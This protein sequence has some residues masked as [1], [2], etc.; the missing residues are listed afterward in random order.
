MDWDKLRIFH[1]VADAGS[2]THAGEVLGVS[3]SALSRQISA[4]EHELGIPLFHRHARGLVRTEQ[5]DLL[6]RTTQEMKQKLDLARMRLVDQRQRP[7]GELRVTAT[8]GVGTHWLAPRLGEF[9][10]MYPDIRLHLLL[11][12]DELD[13]SMREADV[14]LR[15]REPVQTDLIR[16]RLFTMHFHA[17]AA[18]KYLAH[19]SQPETI[20]DLDK[21][22]TI[23]WGGTASH[24]L[25][26]MNCLHRPDPRRPAPR[27]ASLVVNTIP[28]LRSAVAGGVGIAVLPDYMAGAETGLVKILSDV[29]M[30]EMD[31]YLVYPEEL[32]NV[33][34]IQVFRDFLVARASLWDF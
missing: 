1:I 17:W 28:A 4:L 6:L 13:L 32:K 23:A 11:T 14:A 19:N 33:A 25:D 7:H 15:L 10:D 31:C 18:K 12:D 20:E 27:A 3:P 8:V 22:R 24:Y 29:P 26:T 9:L 30:P 2:F 5:G 16:R 34:R 21:H